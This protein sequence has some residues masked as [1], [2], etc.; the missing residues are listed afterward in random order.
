MPINKKD[1]F[2]ILAKVLEGADPILM[3]QILEAMPALG[4]IRPQNAPLATP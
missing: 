1:R 3:D 4:A 2:S